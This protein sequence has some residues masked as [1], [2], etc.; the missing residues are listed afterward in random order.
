MVGAHTTQGAKP[1][2]IPSGRNESH[3]HVGYGFLAYDFF[4]EVI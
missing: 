4:V 1:K 3:T 2:L